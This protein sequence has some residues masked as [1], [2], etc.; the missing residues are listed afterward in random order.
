MLQRLMLKSSG[1]GSQ[2]EPTQSSEPTESSH[3]GRDAALGVGAVGTGTAAAHHHNREPE[4]TGLDSGRSFPLGGNPSTTSDPTYPSSSTGLGASTTAGPHSSDLANKAD[5]RVDSDLDGSRGI[6]NTGYGSGTGPTIGSD[7][8]GTLGHDS[9]LGSGAETGVPST[10]TGS[11]LGQ[12]PESWKHEHSTHGHTYEGDPCGPEESAVGG[13]HFTTGP[14]VTDTANRLD[15]NVASDVTGP[16]NTSSGSALETTTHG[17][18]HLGRDATLA[19]G[20]GAA[21]AGAAGAGAYESSRDT[22]SST[23][24]APS[25]TGPHKSSLLN[26]LDPRV[27]SQKPTQ[28]DSTGITGTP[29][30]VGSTTT[31]PS[32]QVTDKD[33]HHGRD[34]GLAGA[35]GIAGHE[36]EK[37]L[38]SYEPTG[39][40]TS[41]GISN[42]YSSSNLDP[43]V[44]SEPS[45]LGSTGA[46][47]DHHYGRDAG[48]VGAGGVAAYE[49]EKHLGQDH[50]PSGTSQI[51]EP[52]GGPSHD[53][54][55][56]DPVGS[57]YD[58]TTRTTGDHGKE[59]VGTGAGPQSGTG[60]HH[61]RD[62][63]LTGAGLGAGGVAA[64]EAEKHHNRDQPATT[65]SS[66][67]PSSGYEKP[68][69]THTG[70][71]AALVGVGGAGL[72][73]A[74]ESELSK[75]D[76]EKLEK[77]HT[78]EIEKEQK[79]IHKDQIK[80]EKEIEK[81]AKKHEKAIAKEE[82]K[83]DDGKR[84]GG[85][86]G[87][88]HHNKT[89]KNLKDDEIEPQTTGT[90]HG[91]ET[92]A[93]VGTA[94]AVGAGVEHE[95]DKHEHNKL[96][97]DPPADYL[98]SQ[99][100]GQEPEAGYAAQVTG[101]T[102][103][104]AL[105]QGDQIPD[106]PHLTSLGNKADP[107]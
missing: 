14:H 82:K 101:G 3:L 33:H 17:D 66:T 41:T 93:G 94:A 77:E 13:P 50:K 24:P 34:A 54:R 75:K 35:G 43:R 63:G 59:F 56:V 92:A 27:K 6:G 89:D 99:K 25:T 70:R 45:T 57:G 78:K 68:T 26:K 96:H 61:G 11:G 87:L 12:G 29:V 72:G 28:H 88:F 9:G 98:D 2:V 81:E 60:P 10:T 48:L 16:T 18:H 39:T 30:G 83:H 8:Q 38:E 102:G 71:D 46:S 107:R 90:H 73:A 86:L 36:A 74:A 58:Q 19:A 106:G 21:G 80:Y 44:D 1:Y 97:K 37:G 55:S 51:P 79:A 67:Y 52:V 76:A 42:P 53:D 23:N 31:G 49:A 40:T 69:D 32:S 85:I 105:A 95:K 91:A 4:N 47:K 15:P 62:A 103:T 65:D 84:H 7:H 20:V 104:T 5:P 22:P 100:Y 64:Y